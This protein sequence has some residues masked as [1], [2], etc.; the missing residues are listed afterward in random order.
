MAL[1]WQDPSKLSEWVNYWALLFTCT[2]ERKPSLHRNQHF[3]SPWINAPLIAVFVVY[4]LRTSG[5]RCRATQHCF[6]LGAEW[7]CSA[8]ISQQASLTCRVLL[9]GNYRVGCSRGESLCTAR[10][11]LWCSEPLSWHSWGASV[12]VFLLN[13]IVTQCNCEQSHPLDVCIA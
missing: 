10:L 12:M 7:L 3:L 2:I 6:S 4:T 13:A 9:R 1:R 8:G 5:Q 11:W